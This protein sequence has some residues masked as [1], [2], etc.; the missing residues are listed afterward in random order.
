MP[1]GRMPIDLPR[2]TTR[3][4][5]CLSSRG[6]YLYF[7]DAAH[8]EREDFILVSSTRRF[9]EDPAIVDAR[10]PDSTSAEEPLPLKFEKLPARQ[11]RALLN[12]LER[13][14]GGGATRDVHELDE[15]EEDNGSAQADGATTRATI[16]A[17]TLTLFSVGT[18][19][20]P[21]W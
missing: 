11:A 19:E 15:D 2:Q 4:R 18:T 16:A 20:G 21:K 7:K 12:L 13:H 8:G 10:D 17:T 9:E 1:H 3:C 5:H 14:S 6:S